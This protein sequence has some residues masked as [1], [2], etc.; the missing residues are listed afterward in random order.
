MYMLL[1]DLIL[2][3]NKY[4]QQQ[5]QFLLSSAFIHLSLCYIH[6]INGIPSDVLLQITL[7]TAMH[8]Y[9]YNGSNQSNDE[10]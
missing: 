9:M 2:V 6:L 1:I 4:V 3:Q 7:L 10:R 8:T 5:G